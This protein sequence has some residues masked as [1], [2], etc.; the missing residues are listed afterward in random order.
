[1]AL[2]FLEDICVALSCLGTIC[3]ALSCFGA[4]VWHYYF[5]RTFVWHCHVLVAL[6]IELSYGHCMGIILINI[7]VY[8]K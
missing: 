5:Q 6:Y 1:M 8:N 2:T 7:M 4:L 3:V